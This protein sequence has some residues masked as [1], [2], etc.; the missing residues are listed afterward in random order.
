MPKPPKFFGKVQHLDTGVIPT[1]E[2]YFAVLQLGPFSDAEAAGAGSLRLKGIVESAF[3]AAGMTPA[4]EI[5][6]HNGDRA[7]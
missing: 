5:A 4:T 3:L 2:G 6:V 7:S 1:R